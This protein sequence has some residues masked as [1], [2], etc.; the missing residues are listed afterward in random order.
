MTADEQRTLAQMWL[1]LKDREEYRKEL[2]LV[3]EERWRRVETRLDRTETKI[4]ELGATICGIPCLV[5][6]KM[7]ACRDEHEALVAD[8]VADATLRRAGKALRGRHLRVAIAVIAIVVIAAATVA[9]FTEQ[10]YVAGALLALLA[11]ATP[12]VVRTTGG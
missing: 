5:D 12:F 4:D 1:F 7:S 10:D 2:R 3:D 11:A 8:A 9:M 6:E